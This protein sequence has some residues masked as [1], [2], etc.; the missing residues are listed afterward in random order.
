MLPLPGETL[1]S[2]LCRWAW[3][4]GEEPASLTHS[5]GLGYRVWCQDL[6]RSLPGAMHA[7][8]AVA[9]GMEVSH[10]QSMTY[11]ALLAK[12]HVPV[13]RSGFQ[14][15]LTPVG[16][17]HRRRLRFGQL[18]CPLC[19]KDDEQRHVHQDWRYASTWLCKRHQ[20]CLVD[21]CPS[22]GAPFAP[23]RN[24][25]LLLGR[26]E[27]CAFALYTTHPARCSAYQLAL[28]VH[29]DALWANAEAGD[30]LPLS[31]AYAA[32][33]EIAKHSPDF[34][35]AGEPWNY[36]RALERGQL[37]ETVL[38]QA[39]KIHP[40]VGHTNAATIYGRVAPTTR[41]APRV[42][43][44]VPKDRATRANKLMQIALRLHPK[45]SRASVVIKK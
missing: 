40:R 35:Y 8:V 15:W 45:K 4:R 26:C 30:P 16:L 10:I 13:Q 22:C 19:L 29:I 5:L 37:M 23:Y 31:R 43:W 6:D 34:A 32:I 41:A 24:D 21:S 25:S 39:M 9:A 38:A 33:N 12:A 17:Y 36:W 27:R 11:C 2:F 1:G 28:Q 7:K 42:C 18:Y 14:A 3:A 44:Q 20:V